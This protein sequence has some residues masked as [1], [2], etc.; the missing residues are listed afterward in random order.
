[1][2]ELTILVF[3]DERGFLAGVGG[4]VGVLVLELF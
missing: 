2:G 1:M 4:E 3:I